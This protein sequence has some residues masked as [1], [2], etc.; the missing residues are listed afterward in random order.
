M[1]DGI[2]ELPLSEELIDEL[3]LDDPL[4]DDVLLLL[5]EELL[6]DDDELQDRL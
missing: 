6:D 1:S 4:T 3:E 2:E 5:S